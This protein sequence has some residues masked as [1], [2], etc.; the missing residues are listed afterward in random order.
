LNFPAKNLR[1]IFAACGGGRVLPQPF[2]RGERAV[3]LGFD[4]LDCRGDGLNG[5]CHVMGIG[6][7]QRLS[8][9]HQSHM[10]LPE[11]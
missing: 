4:P 5:H 7:D 11:E 6:V 1:K 8:I 10:A 2:V 9:P 3:A